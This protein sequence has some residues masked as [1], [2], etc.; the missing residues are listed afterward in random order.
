MSFFDVGFFNLIQMEY[1]NSEFFI[2]SVIAAFIGIALT[3]IVSN[4]SRIYNYFHNTKKNSKF[5]INT[6]VFIIHGVMI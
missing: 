4:S 5:L 6:S 1:L 3:L 2:T